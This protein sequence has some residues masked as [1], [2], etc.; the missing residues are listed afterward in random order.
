MSI[1]VTGGTGYIGSHT[2]VEL[3][4]AGESVVVIDNLSNSKIE[5][6]NRIRM[7]THKNVTFYQADIL[8]RAFLSEIFEKEDIKTVI[9]FAALKSV[10]ESILQPSLYYKNNV[11]GLINLLEVM[12]EY[13]V[14]NLVYSSSA[15]VYGTSEIIPVVENARLHA[16]NPYGKTKI[17]CEDI[18]KD[19]YESDKSYNI[20]ILR[21]FNPIGAHISGLIGED[22]L[23]ESKNLLPI[24]TQVAIGKKREVSVFGSDYDTPDGTGVR[25]FIHV[26]DLALGHIKAIEHLN[27]LHTYNLGTGKGT[28]VLEVIKTFEKVSKRQIRYNLTDRRSGDVSVSYADCTLAYEELGWEAKR[29]LDAMCLDAWRWQ[30]RN[31]MG[32]P[33]RR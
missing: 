10:E 16:V 1:L 14:K 4:N 31:P 27:G 18:L 30:F 6:L 25:D 8:N 26:V 9:H 29:N 15:T 17:I 12:E 24:L 20:T 33:V 19:L 3:L 5:V 13:H 21:Y 11:M 28:S 32:Y 22:P 23:G 2:L 7:I